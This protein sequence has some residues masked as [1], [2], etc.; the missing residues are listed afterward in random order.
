MGSCY[1]LSNLKCRKHF[2]KFVYLGRKHFEKFVYFR[3]K[4]FEK[5]CKV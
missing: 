4:H 1:L 3:L 2:E 5:F